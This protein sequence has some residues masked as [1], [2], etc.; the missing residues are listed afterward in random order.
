MNFDPFARGGVIQSIFED[1]SDGFY[2]PYGIAVDFPLRGL[3]KQDLLFLLT[4]PEG[5]GLQSGIQNL[6]NGTKDFL[7]G[8]TADIQT[9][10]F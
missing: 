6:R 9:G 10:D 2:G 5:K 1:I 3:Q 8:D 4:G 7:K